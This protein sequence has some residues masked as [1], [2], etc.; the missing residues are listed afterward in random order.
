MLGACN[1]RNRPTPPHVLE[2]EAQRSDLTDSLPAKIESPKPVFLAL[3]PSKASFIIS[4]E[5]AK[6]LEACGLRCFNRNFIPSAICQIDRWTNVLR[7]MIGQWYLKGQSNDA[8]NYRFVITKTTQERLLKHKLHTPSSSF[9][10]TQA[11]RRKRYRSWLKR[12][13]NFTQKWMRTRGA[14]TQRLMRHFFN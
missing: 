5:T 13:Q 7:R 12:E 4:I 14:A 3:V 6:V 1:D 8:I 2:L 9:N 11:K 10:M